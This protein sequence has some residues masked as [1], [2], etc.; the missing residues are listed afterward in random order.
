MLNCPK[1]TDVL[2]KFLNPANLIIMFS[3]ILAFMVMQSL[4]FWFIVSKSVENVIDEKTEL[5]I[6]LGENIPQ[7]KELLVDYIKD[8]EETDKILEKAY[9]DYNQ[10]ELYNINLIWEWI[11]PPFITILTMLIITCVILVFN[12]NFKF[13]RKDFY[14]L[15]TVFLAFFT[16]ILFYF[17]VISRSR[18]LSDMEV[19]KILLT[20]ISDGKDINTFIFEILFPDTVDVPQT[21][22]P[23]LPTI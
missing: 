8:S 22:P 17:T 1:T 15:C 14:L 19:L 9:K 18:I 6:K 16:E 4:F 23:N 11:G 2:K 20:V 5:L 12:K 3:N 7:I 21:L 10:R 13:T